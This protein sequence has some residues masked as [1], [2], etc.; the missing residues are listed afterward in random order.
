MTRQAALL[1]VDDNELNR[2]ALSR[3]LRRQ[4]YLVTAA[5]DGDEALALIAAGRYDLVLLD[6]EMPGMSGL[7]VLTGLRAADRTCSSTPKTGD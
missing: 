4:G 2:D 1:V 5:A 3:H 6:V 7:D